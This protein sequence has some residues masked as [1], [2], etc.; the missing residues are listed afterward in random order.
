[1]ELHDYEK[2]HLAMLH[3]NLAECAVLLKRGGNFP[4][5]APCELALYGSGARRPVKG[6]TGSGEVNSRFF[7]TVEQGLEAA[8]FTVTTKAWLDAYD[9][10]RDQARAAF[11]KRLK[12]EAKE[13]HTSAMM[14][15]LGATPPEPEYEL[16]LGAPGDTAIY[17]L[18]RISGEGADR[19]LEKGDFLLTDSEIRDILALQ[20]RC[21]NFLLVLNTGGP[22]DLTPVLSVDNILLLSQLGVETG[23]ALAEIV[24]GRQ[25]PSGKLAATWPTA[26]Q[27]GSMEF[28]CAEDTRYREGIYVGY[29]WFDSVGERPLF[30]F[31]YGKSYTDFRL[32]EAEAVASA[33]RVGLRVPVENVGEFRGREVVQAYV[34]VPAGKLDQPYQAL[35]AFAKSAELAPGERQSLRFAFDLLDLASYDAVSAAWVL[36]AGDYILRIGADSVDTQ[37]AAVLRLPESVYVKKVRNALGKPDFRDFAPPPRP[38]A[39]SGQTPVLLLD[40]AEFRTQTVDYQPDFP[41]APEAAKLTDE[42]LARLSNGRFGK[43]L[44]SVVGSASTSVCGAAGETSDLPGFRPIVMADGPAGLRL[45]A[46]YYRDRKGVHGAALPI[47]D[48]ML[49]FLPKPVQGVLRLASRRPGKGAAVEYQYCTAIPISAALAQSWNPDL[50]RLCGDLVGS[51]MERFGVDLWL[52]P[53][54]NLQRSCLCG[55]NFEYFSEDPLLT[56]VMAAALTRGVQRHPGKGV[57]IKHFAANNQEYHRTWSNSLVSERAMRE[58]YLRG[59]AHCI[60]EAAPKAVMSSY[61]LINGKHTSMRRDLL[62]GV[63]RCEFGFRGILMTDWLI[64]GGMVPKGAAHPAPEPW[65]VAAAGGDLYMPGSEHDYKNVLAALRAGK[66]SRRQLEINATRIL[67]FRAQSAPPSRQKGNDHA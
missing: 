19:R 23:A 25:T 26:E 48:S 37:I 5:K 28:G 3:G 13:Q 52:A 61:N 60:R 17:V 14:L 46:K 55:R 29:R 65:K 45:T 7:V 12:Q 59:F 33:T 8:G 64:R 51:E 6:G 15:A 21:A 34:S 18:S 67:Q 30:P 20:S 44:A 38:R 11:R 53:A 49:S 43:G 54:L 2:K 27:A 39:I 36:E 4:L 24:L 42:Q 31:G 40:P 32:G 66:L 47:P 35:A 9:R 1:M 10:I 62:H 56:G 58:L 57:T 22:V 50:A 16:P 63:L 41:I